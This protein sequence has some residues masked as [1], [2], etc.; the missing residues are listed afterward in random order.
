MHLLF[1]ILERI[2]TVLTLG[3]ILFYAPFAKTWIRAL[4]VP[5]AL[6]IMGILV[7][8]F[9]IVAFKEESPPGIGF[10]LAPF[11]CALFAAIARVIGYVIFKI[12]ILKRL[13]ED[14]RAKLGCQRR[15]PP[16]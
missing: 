12:P 15:S 5:V 3:L 7:T 10:A 13:E 2:I 1:L 8:E 4:T 11:A 6:I 16:K 14:V 9:T